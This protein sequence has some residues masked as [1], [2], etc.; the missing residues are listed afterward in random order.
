M[1]KP[2]TGSLHLRRIDPARNMAR[3]YVLSFQPTL[4]G[5]T[6]LIRNWG[7][8]GTNG[9]AMVETFDENAA[10]GE[11]Y[12][13]LERRKRRRGYTSPGEET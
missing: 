8:I 5:G 12:A 9:Q 6:S 1:P 3:F 7:R 4:F 2:E 13:R 11:A 10:A